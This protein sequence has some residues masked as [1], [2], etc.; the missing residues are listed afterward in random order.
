[1]G[2]SGHFFFLGSLV[3]SRCGEGGT[4]QANN[5]GVCL[6]CLSHTGPAPAH[7]AHSSGSR[8]LG[9]ELSEAGLGLHTP[10]RSK[11]LR[12]RHSGSAQRRSLGWACAL[13]PSQVRAAQVFGER[14]RCDLSPFPSLLFCFLGVQLAPLLRR[15]VTAQDPKKSQLAK[16]P[17]CSLVANVSLGLGLP[18]SGSGCL[19]PEGDGLQPASSAQ[20]FVL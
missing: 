19:S 6:Q 20:F 12:L 15:M 4:L 11:L 2:G 7:S 16:K 9:W 14:G 5:T 18:T 13:C 8:L 1:M 10:P 3:Q 17:A